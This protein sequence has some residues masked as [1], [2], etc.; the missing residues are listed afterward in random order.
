M[1]CV[2]N[3]TLKNIESG[4]IIEV[5][6]SP[7]TI[8]RGLV[9]N[10]VIP[11]TVVSRKHCFL[12][13]NEESRWILQD[14]S[15]NGTYL[16]GI[17]IKSSRSSPL[18]DSD[19]I[20]LSLENEQ[21]TFHYSSPEDISDEQLC[22]I[23][24]SVLQDVEVVTEEVITDPM[25]NMITIPSAFTEDTNPDK[26]ND[27]ITSHQGSVPAN[28]VMLTKTDRTSNPGIISSL[29]SVKEMMIIIE[30]NE[31]GLNPNKKIKTG[32]QNSE[33]NTSIV[34]LTNQSICSR[35]S[36]IIIENPPSTDEP[37]PSKAENDIQVKEELPDQAIPKSSSTQAV[38]DNIDEMEDEMQCSICS[39]MFVK[40]TTL[41]CA[42]TFCKFCI[43]TWKKNKSECPICRCRITSLT[44]TLVLDNVIEK[45][46]QNAPEE[47]QKHRKELLED[48][49]KEELK[50][51]ATMPSSKSRRGGRNHRNRGGSSNHG[52][53]NYNARVPQSL[54]VPVNNTR[55]LQVVHSSG[56]PIVRNATVPPVVTNPVNNASVIEVESSSESS[57]THSETDSEAWR[58]EYDNDDWYDD[59]I[60]GAYYGGYG[61]CYSCGSRGHWRNGCPYR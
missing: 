8:G 57:D 36:I 44:S 21:Y 10:F 19:V 1:A 14:T 25:E 42:H 5:N 24:D 34:D 22:M 17:L 16:N 29:N 20:G 55:V 33:K 59:G 53:Y 58:D 3:P 56:A 15:T 4:N 38:Q 49:K 7:F 47:M 43:E 6:T 9:C 46:I 28:P 39:E 45:I 26:K 52:T 13:K 37:G 27:G 54:A 60:P 61:H 30:N 18:K 41:N 12:E 35:S 2:E 11:S 32:P 40:A 31:N 48:R 50:K 23:A 51:Q